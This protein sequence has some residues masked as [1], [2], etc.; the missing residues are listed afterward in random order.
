MPHIARQ[1]LAQRHMEWLYMIRGSGVNRVVLRVGYGLVMR[2][3]R[4]MGSW[5]WL[6]EWLK[7][8]IY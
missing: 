2:V 7:E 3:D 4:S 6:R 1:S 5:S 8:M